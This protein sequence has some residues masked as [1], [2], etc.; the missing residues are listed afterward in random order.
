MSGNV[1]QSEYFVESEFERTI[2]L[3]ILPVRDPDCFDE[4]FFPQKFLLDLTFLVDQYEQELFDCKH[5]SM[6]C[7]SLAEALKDY[8]E[9]SGHL[10]ATSRSLQ[11]PSRPLQP[12][13]APS[14]PPPAL[15]TTQQTPSRTSKPLAAP[16]RAPPDPPEKTS[17]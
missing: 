12:P 17:F 4:P 1:R 16:S 6:Q 2:L 14:C 8:W 7:K 15:P 5:N 3:K 9:E 10:A 13:P 11:S